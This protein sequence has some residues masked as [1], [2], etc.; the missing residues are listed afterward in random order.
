MTRLGPFLLAV[1][2]LGACTGDG[3]SPRRSPASVTSLD[4]AAEC[5]GIGRPPPRGEVTFILDGDL[6]ASDLAGNHRCLIDLEAVASTLRGPVAPAWNAPGD[7]VLLG[8][9]AIDPDLTV[10]WL[11]KWREGDFLQWSRPTGTSV[12]HLTSGGRLMK[13][14]SSGGTI[15]DISFLRRHDDVVYHPAGLHIATSGL[16]DDGSYGL[17]L[18]T[19]VGT[20]TQLLAVGEK[21]R[22]LTDLQFSQDGRFIYYSAR[23][24]P[25]EWHLHRLLIG[26]SASLE[27]LD[28]TRRPVRYEISAFDV[29]RVAWFEAGDCV[30]GVPGTLELAGVRTDRIRIPDE[31]R[32]RNLVPIGWLPHGRLVVE[33]RSVG[34]STAGSRGIYILSSKEPVLLRTLES[35]LVSVRVKLPPPPPP[36][37]EEQEVVA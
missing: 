13:R 3:E 17:Y 14:P 15:R 2:M 20:E 5:D 1:V 27:T 37:D 24:G 6:W 31:L 32:E 4:P 10:T 22:Y 12:I 36:P 8:G 9:V 7:H 34:C 26:E 21:A 30:A 29:A 11:A 23:H 28:K 18:A 35:P 16:A 33:A 25:D 19:N